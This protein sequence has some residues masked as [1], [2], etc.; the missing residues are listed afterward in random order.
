MRRLLL[1][2]HLG[3][4]GRERSFR[5]LFFSTFGSGVGTWL[6]LVAL[7]VDI[8]ER[9][10]S[11][12]W[13]ALL[14]VADLLPMVLLGLLVGPLIDRLSRKRLLVGADLARFAVF[15]AL[16]FAGSA[17]AIVALA[18]LAGVA[19]GVFR[20][21]AYAGLPNLVEDRDLP[22]ANSLL[23]TIDNLTWA[24][25]SL[26]GGALVQASGPHLAYWINAGTFLVSAALIG[27]I[28]KRLMQAAPAPSRGHLRDL[29]DGFALV[30]NSRALFTVL[31]AWN[32]SM[33][34]N[35]FVNVGE[36]FLAF[37]VFNSGRFGLGLLMGS[38]GIGLAIGAFFAGTSI[39]QRGLAKVY[40]AALALMA[41][42]VGS[43][44]AAPNVWVAAV[45]VVLSGAGN[46]AAVVCNALLVQRG[47]PDRMRGRAFTVLMSSNVALLTL[48]MFVAGW[49]TNTIGPRWVWAI[50]ASLSAVAALVGLG[51]ARG[52]HEGRGPMEEPTP[53]PL[54]EPVQQ[55][56]GRAL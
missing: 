18:A 23:Q 53:L 5:L 54:A 45:C 52:V 9:T 10:H 49:L 20:P 7:Q 28:P 36:P 3:L 50:S 30:R 31:I 48:G 42:G 27:G 12:A 6:A 44:A 35:G 2:K 25:G 14:L 16:P 39:E 11:P 26:A 47:A 41:I 19:S 34:A 55:Q 17:I 38:A 40:G 43:A 29:A 4:L 56:A 1:G 51:L 13:M 32:I 22:N 33:V 24:A 46:G 37:R 21:T 15:C 8:Y